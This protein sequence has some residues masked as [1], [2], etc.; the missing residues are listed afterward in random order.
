MEAT[1]PKAERPMS[2]EG[3]HAV[4]SRVEVE[5]TG[6]QV[7][8]RGAGESVG[9][10]AC[11]SAHE[12]AD[13]G[14]GEYTGE[15]A[16]EARGEGSAPSTRLFALTPWLPPTWPPNMVPYAQE[17]G[18]HSMEHGL[19]NPPDLGHQVWQRVRQC[20]LEHYAVVV[21][22]TQLTWEVTLADQGEWGW[23]Q[24]CSL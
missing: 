13:E 17:S 12:D 16:G 23:R 15:G 24:G 22:R 6:G 20:D 11:E 4:S 9:E 2:Q 14:A 18:M 3:L 19:P 5:G 7:Q 10:H 21:G 1:E 8:V